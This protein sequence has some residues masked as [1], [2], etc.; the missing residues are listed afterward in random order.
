MATNL[1]DFRLR[2]QDKEQAKVVSFVGDGS[3]TI[4]FLDAVPVTAA[5]QTVKVNGTSYTE[6]ASSPTSTQY[7]FD[8]DLGRITFGAA[9]ALGAYVEVDWKTTIFTDTELTDIL[10]TRSITAASS[11][12]LKSDSFWPAIR[13][14]VEILMMDAQRRFRWGAAGGQDVDQTEIYRNL[15]SWHDKLTALLLEEAVAGGGVESWSTEQQY[16]P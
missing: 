6:V 12:A 8:D 16:Y 15:A 3:R 10:L 2:I 9:P 5:S 4:Y 1:V 13:D 7:I 14:I 11:G